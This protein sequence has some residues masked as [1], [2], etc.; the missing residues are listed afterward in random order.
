MPSKAAVTASLAGIT[1]VGLL[2]AKMGFDAQDR[3]YNKS[4]ALYHR[5]RD[6]AHEKWGTV[7]PNKK[8]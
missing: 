1:A 8:Y 3:G 7:N 6:T 5:G 2:V 4:L